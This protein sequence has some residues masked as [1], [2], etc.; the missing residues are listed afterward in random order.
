MSQ[1]KTIAVLGGGGR[2]G[3]FLISKLTENGYRLKVLLRNPENFEF[4]SPLV[5]IV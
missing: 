4:H 3:K 2:T 5:E 1:V